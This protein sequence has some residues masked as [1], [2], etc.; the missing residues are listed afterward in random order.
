[1]PQELISQLPPATTANLSDQVPATQESVKPGTGITRY[2]TV[3]QQ[4]NAASL[5]PQTVATDQIDGV[6]V[7]S[8][9]TMLNASPASIVAAGAAG[10]PVQSVAGKTGNV[11]LAVTDVAGAAPL[12]APTFS[13]RVTFTGMPVLLDLPNFDPGILGALWE[14]NGVLMR[15]KG[16]SSTAALVDETGNLIVDANGNIILGS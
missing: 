13:G 12:A 15:S 14:N 2:L 4:L 16:V 5:L 7:S 11:T 1:M 8:V 10:V 3:R 6:L 9:G